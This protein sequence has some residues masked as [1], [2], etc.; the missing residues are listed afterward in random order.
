MPL[1][2]P[3]SLAAKEKWWMKEEPSPCSPLTHRPI[4]TDLQKK[5]SKPELSLSK[6][7]FPLW[8]MIHLPSVSVLGVANVVHVV[9]YIEHVP[10]SYSAD[11][12]N[13]IRRLI[14]VGQTTGLPTGTRLP[15]EQ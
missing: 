9:R 6:Q 13:V 11:S 1:F 7:S 5:D 12:R 4:Q 8:R 2:S 15:R 3:I 14:V 10:D